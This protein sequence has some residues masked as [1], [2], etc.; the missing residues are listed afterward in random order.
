MC[1]VG[2]VKDACIETIETKNPENYKTKT[3][4]M[5]KYSKK[6]DFLVFQPL[7]DPIQTHKLFPTSNIY[8]Y[9]LLLLQF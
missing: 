4:L 7:L 9:F 6:K 3:N 1:Q 8:I 2:A 5:S